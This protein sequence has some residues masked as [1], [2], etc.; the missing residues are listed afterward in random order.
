MAAETTFLLNLESIL[1]DFFAITIDGA[2]VMNGLY[3]K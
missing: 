1:E 2:S 3:R